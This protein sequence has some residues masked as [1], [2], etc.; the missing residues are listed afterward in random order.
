MTFSLTFSF[1]SPLFFFQF[2]PYSLREEEGRKKLEEGR[3][4]K[5]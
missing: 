2:L 5:K 3:G 1:N 4:G